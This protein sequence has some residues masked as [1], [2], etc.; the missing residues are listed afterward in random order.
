V[1]SIA[2]RR[3]L[4]ARRL[5]DGGTLAPVCDAD[6]NSL[7]QI[8]GRSCRWRQRP[9]IGIDPTDATIAIESGSITA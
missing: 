5:R 8:K 6:G 9:G 1:S 4:T 7:N 2:L 3:S